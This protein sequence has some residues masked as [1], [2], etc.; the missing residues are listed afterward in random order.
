M[1]EDPDLLKLIFS[2]V[3]GQSCK[4]S[5]VAKSIWKKLLKYLEE[6]DMCIFEDP[7]SR[8]KIYRNLTRAASAQK[9]DDRVSLYIKW[10]CEFGCA[11]LITKEKD[12]SQIQLKL[13][14]PESWSTGASSSK[15]S[16]MEFW[17]PK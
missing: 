15:S 9:E 6:P 5:K 8:D 17:S 2:N 3:S 13:I 7:K 16:S 12:E 14:A 4:E 1:A 11:L 10:L